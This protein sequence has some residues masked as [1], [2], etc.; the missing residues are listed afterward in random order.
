MAPASKR[1][2]IG[3]VSAEVGLSPQAIRF[4]ESR[5]LLGPSERA[6]KGYRY[7]GDEEVARIRKIQG[8]Q[9]I[10][11]SLDDI[12]KVLPLYYE[13]P[14]G[15]A[16]KRKIIEILRAQLEETDRKIAAM[17]SFRDEIMRNI[18]RFELFLKHG[19][20]GKGR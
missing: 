17:Q 14:T 7:Y 18:T 1:L 10:G 9:Q 4:Y 12:G 5:G 3:E 16:G 13:D 15:A 19:H 20:P 6:G 2:R 11:L 8:L